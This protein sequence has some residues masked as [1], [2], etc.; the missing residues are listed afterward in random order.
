MTMADASTT[1]RIFLLRSTAVASAMA[2]PGLSCALELGGGAGP[3]W[4]EGAANPPRDDTGARFLTTAERAAVDAITARLIPSEGEG[5]GAREAQVT[6]FID[7]QLAGFYGRAERWYMDGPFPEPLATQGYQS[8]LAPS[9]LWR[10]GL[11]ALDAH[12]RQA[13]GDRTFVQITSTEQDALLGAMER[14]E[15]DLAPVPTR[16][17]FEFM[18]KMTVE[19]YFSDPIHGGNHDMV[20]WSF[21]GFPGARYDWRDHIN[22]NGA[23]IDV[24]PIGL[25]GGPAWR[26]P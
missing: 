11:A 6:D 23:R 21:I 5:P 19:G 25:A 10:A 7:R 16:T 12:C 3:P 9:A 17:F 4:E 18:L 20:A 14:G 8:P 2:V 26:T 22:H 15:I 13:Y 1:R 24:A